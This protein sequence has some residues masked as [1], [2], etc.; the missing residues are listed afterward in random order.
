MNKYTLDIRLDD[1]IIIDTLFPMI[2]PNGVNQIELNILNI[3]D[4]KNEELVLSID[5]KSTKVFKTQKIIKGKV[6]IN[7]AELEKAETEI[8]ISTIGEESRIYK[9]DKE[10]IT[11]HRLINTPNADKLSKI[12]AILLNDNIDLK[13]RLHNIEQQL[14]VDE[15]L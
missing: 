2:I 11:I 3:P 14:Y 4:F 8:R 1:N 9:L 5:N 6:K 13:R 10:V 15:I 12:L 7:I